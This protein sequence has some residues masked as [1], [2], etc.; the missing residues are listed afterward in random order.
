MPK[1]PLVSLFF[2]DRKI[3]VLQLDSR[4]QKVKKHAT[5]DLPDDLIVRHKVTD[6]IALGKILQNT[7]D[8]LGIKER[9]V[10]IIIPEFSTFAKVIKVPRIDTGDLDEAVKWQAQE[11]LPGSQKDMVMDWKIVRRQEKEYEILVAAVGREILESYV[12]SAENAGFFP[13]IVET[14]SLAISRVVP[15]KTKRA[16][17][18]YANIGEAILV[19]IED[20]AIVGSSIVSSSDQDDIVKTATRIVAHYGEHEIEKILIG[21]LDVK[22]DLANKLQKAL[23]K[24]TEGITTRAKGLTSDELQHYLIPIS[25]Q[26]REPSEPA[27]PGT[28]NLMPIYLV[29]R[30]K[31]AKERT[32]LWGLNLTITLFVWMCLIVVVGTYIFLN[33]TL[34]DLKRVNNAQSDIANQRVQAAKMVNEVNS[35]SERVV[36]INNASTYPQIVLN[37]ISGSTPAG[38]SVEDYNLDLDRGT[39]ELRG[40]AVDRLSLINFK[41]RLE[42]NPKVSEVLI[43]IS[44]FQVESNIKFSLSYKYSTAL[45][46]IPN[47]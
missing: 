5:L 11:F 29:T 1:R 2:S 25:L 38:V 39:V 42:E 10:G 37:D 44:S 32:Q 17:V 46:Q 15:E 7:W 21:G 8:K 30:Y 36:K 26:F 13:Q 16:L 3:Q 41:Q 33:Q 9:S 12:K 43:P 23:G 45:E 6:H 19:L 28:I 35:L 31:S 20:G 40:T 24:P 4:L 47:N 22:A 18:V 14:P 27:D 34:G